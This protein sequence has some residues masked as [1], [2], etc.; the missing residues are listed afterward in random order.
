MLLL[1]K[2]K[3]KQFCCMYKRYLYETKSDLGK[4][5]YDS[6]ID[7]QDKLHQNLA[8]RRTLASIGTHDLDTVKG[9]FRYVA[10]EPSNISFL[11]LK[12]EKEMTA[13]QLME[14]YEKDN[15]MKQFVPIIKDSDKYPLI[16]DSNNIICSL[17]P[18][19]N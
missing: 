13:P 3:V 9:P 4:A 6:F 12:Q 5:S 16:V 18:I 15:F 7:L 10:R 1:L 14:V 2:E 11:A 19:I 17:P 8:R